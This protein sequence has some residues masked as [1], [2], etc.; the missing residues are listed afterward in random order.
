M[1]AY[2]GED[3]ALRS[4]NLEILSKWVVQLTHWTLYPQEC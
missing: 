1:Q 2:R 3:I 4:T